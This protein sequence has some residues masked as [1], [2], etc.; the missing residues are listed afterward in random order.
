MP[1]NDHNQGIALEL[2]ER[3]I[4]TIASRKHLYEANKLNTF[5]FEVDGEEQTGY[6]RFP[7]ARLIA[8][9]GRVQPTRNSRALVI[10]QG[11]IID[12]PE[13]GLVADGD[14]LVPHPMH[15]DPRYSAWQSSNRPKRINAQQWVQA[16][17]RDL[18]M[19]YVNYLHGFHGFSVTQRPAKREGSQRKTEDLFVAR[20]SNGRDLEGDDRTNY[21]VHLNAFEISVNPDYEQGFKN[22]V[23]GLEE[24]RMRWESAF[25]IEDEAL[26]KQAL[27]QI[28]Q[29]IHFLGGVYRDDEA[30]TWWARPVDVGMVNITNP[31][32]GEAN[33][34]ALYK[35]RG[36]ELSENLFSA[37]DEGSPTATPATAALDAAGLSLPDEQPF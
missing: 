5:T 26:R 3:E 15:S 2:P 33:D 23:S 31:L 35:Q 10:T 12:D 20:P 22:F 13:I 32:T 16:E 21:G 6:F 9:T 30:R 24:Q 8:V 7:R 37:L 27:E 4:A 29:N 11:I 17:N 19:D 28:A 34:W 36:S 1:E 14:T 18:V 25:E